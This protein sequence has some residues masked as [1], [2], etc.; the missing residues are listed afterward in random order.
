MAQHKSSERIPRDSPDWYSVKTQRGSPVVLTHPDD[1]LWALHD[2]VEIAPRML[3]RIAKY[4]GLCS[5][6][7]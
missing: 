3:A 1:Y 7:L 4:T 5:E 6:D 2:R